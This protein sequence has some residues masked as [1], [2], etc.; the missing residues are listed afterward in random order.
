MLVSPDSHFVETIALPSITFASAL[1]VKGEAAKLNEN[2]LRIC[3]QTGCELRVKRSP[4]AS[5]ATEEG[6]IRIEG[7]NASKVYEAKAEVEKVLQFYYTDCFQ[8]LEDLPP[9]IAT[10]MYELLP[11]LRAKYNVV[12]SLPT[13]TTLKVLRTLRSTPRKLQSS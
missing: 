2:A 10:R 9:S 1:E 7:T 8:T 6:I 4:A 3:K 5:G 11:T 12:F 13:K